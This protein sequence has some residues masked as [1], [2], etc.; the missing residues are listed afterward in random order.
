MVIVT[1]PVPKN[2]C[3]QTENWKKKLFFYR[4][5]PIIKPKMAFGSLLGHSKW[6]YKF[7]SFLNTR[8]LLLIYCIIVYI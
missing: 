2:T 8:K 3:A 4:Y 1:G 6:F 5:Q 7:W